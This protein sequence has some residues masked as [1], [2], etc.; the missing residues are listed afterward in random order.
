MEKQ[1][2]NDSKNRNVG[3]Y[4]G[5]RMRCVQ[6]TK[7]LSRSKQRRT[8]VIWRKELCADS[9]HSLIYWY[10]IRLLLFKFNCNITLTSYICI[11]NKMKNEKN[12]FSLVF[13]TSDGKENWIELQDENNLKHSING[14]SRGRWKKA[15]LT[16]KRIILYKVV[17]YT[18]TFLS[19]VVLVFKISKIVTWHIGGSVEK[20]YKKLA[21]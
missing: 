9:P 5:W 13:I 7:N 12:H 1:T 20:W 4:D 3:R 6:T 11:T 15:L 18:A 21:S 2:A 8:V 17:L 10:K 16:A 14:C 19:C